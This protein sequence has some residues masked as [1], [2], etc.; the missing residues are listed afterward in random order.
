MPCGR[1]SSSVLPGRWRRRH[2]LP[3]SAFLPALRPPACPCLLQTREP[4]RTLACPHRSLGP[5]AAGLWETAGSPR[6]ATVVSPSTGAAEAQQGSQLDGAFRAQLAGAPLRLLRHLLLC[7]VTLAEP[8]A[9]SEAPGRCVRLL[10]ALCSQ[11]D[12]AGQ[13]GAAGEQM[14]L[15]LALLVQLQRS[16]LSRAERSSEAQEDAAQLQARAAL[17]EAAVAAVAS[18]LPAAAGEGVAAA[19]ATV[20]A[21]PGGALRL[22]RPAEVIAAAAAEVQAAARTAA[23]HAAVVG[24]LE[25]R[26]ASEHAAE[27]R[28]AQAVRGAAL[29]AL[30]ELL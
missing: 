21:P 1:P 24:Q 29:E 5:L 3:V 8:A 22:L 30:G 27:R 6:T 20:A 14:Q 23:L 7:S 10:P 9:G 26:L 25:S 11:L 4:T 16:L 12:A 2:A 19:A 17:A 13:E 18:A 15:L 28:A